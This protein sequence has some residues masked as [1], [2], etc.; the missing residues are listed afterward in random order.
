M[1]PESPNYEP[2]SVTDYGDLEEL[3]A[4]NSGP[5]LDDVPEG[6]ALFSTRGGEPGMS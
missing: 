2:P 3:T 5:A 6:S 1:T 4:S